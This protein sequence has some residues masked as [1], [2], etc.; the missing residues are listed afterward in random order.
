MKK[1]LLTLA[2]AFCC[3]AGQGQTTAI[4]VYKRQDYDF[5]YKAGVVAIFGPGTSV[6]KAAVQIMNI[7]LDEEE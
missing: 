1:I 2:L 3:V 5:L 7:L 6:A 4:D